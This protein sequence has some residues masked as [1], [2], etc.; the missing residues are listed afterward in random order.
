MDGK[1][2]QRPKNQD[3][4]LGEGEKLSAEVEKTLEKGR[5][6]LAHTG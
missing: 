2:W 5:R 6:A 1:P 3:K 4:R